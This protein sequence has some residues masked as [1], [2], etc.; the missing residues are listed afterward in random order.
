MSYTK[1][2]S[3]SAN[4]IPDLV[5][6]VCFAAITSNLSIAQLLQLV[7]QEGVKAALAVL[8]SKPRGRVTFSDIAVLT[9]IPRQEVA[10]LLD[11]HSEKKPQRQLSN[12]LNR[13]IAGW[14]EDR[15]F[16]GKNGRPRRLP[17]RGDNSF[18]DVVRRYGRDVTVQSAL[19]QLLLA[20]RAEMRMKTIALRASR[21]ASSS[22]TS[23]DGDSVQQNRLAL[24]RL[25]A[26]QGRSSRNQ[27][28]FLIDSVDIANV[29]EQYAPVFFRRATRT[30][31]TALVRLPTY[32]SASAG[33]RAGADPSNESSYRAFVCLLPNVR[34]EVLRT[35]KPRR[36][37]TVSNGRAS[38]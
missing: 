2:T 15:D 7:R 21:R 33:A 6:A 30:L 8:S 27:P 16:R 22:A 14:S 5:R 24:I 12:T 32:K 28:G 17:L 13:I 29:A 19:R 34:H 1:P 25:L 18:T 26:E 20:G 9:G 35:P 36:H 3:E 38:Q 4:E 23:F 10:K 31:R 37:K 11:N